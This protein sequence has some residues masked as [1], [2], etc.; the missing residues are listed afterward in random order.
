MVPKNQ[1]TAFGRRAVKSD[2]PTLK[3]A[4]PQAG[5]AKA[6]MRRNGTNHDPSEDGPEGRLR[7]NGIW[8]AMNL[9]CR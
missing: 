4:S 8:D 6:D 3:M 7:M 1:V 5:N 9:R 2:W